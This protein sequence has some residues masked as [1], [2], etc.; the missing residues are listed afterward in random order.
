MLD[1]LATKHGVEQGQLDAAKALTLKTL[2]GCFKLLTPAGFEFGFRVVKEVHG[3]M[4]VWTKAQLAMGVSAEEAMKRWVVGLDYAV[5]QKVLPKIHGNRSALGD[6]LKALAAFLGG[7]HADSDPP[8]KYALG[9]EVPT[10]IEPVEAIALP[11]GAEFVQCR[12]KLLDMHGRLLSRNYVS[13]V[14]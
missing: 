14:K 2:D 6:S 8:A 10:R 12:A 13:F 11:V 4:H 9:A 5:F 7:N 1:L 3:Y